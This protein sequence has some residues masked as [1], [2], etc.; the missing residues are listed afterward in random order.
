MYPYEERIRK[1]IFLNVYSFLSCCNSICGSLGLGLYHT[2]IEVEYSI[3]SMQP[4]LVYVSWLCWRGHW[5]V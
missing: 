3:W 1:P 2:A 4:N 5:G